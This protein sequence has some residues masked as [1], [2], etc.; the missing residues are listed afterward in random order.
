MPRTGVLTA[1]GNRSCPRAGRGPSAAPA[2][3]AP[4]PRPSRPRAATAAH[5]QPVPHSPRPPNQPF[6]TRPHLPLM[7]HIMHQTGS[8]GGDD[9]PETRPTSHF[10]P[11]FR[12]PTPAEPPPSRPS[13]AIPEGSHTR[14]S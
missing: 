10:D 1:H 13:D 12:P 4:S 8:H 9:T 5:H 7:G 14:P 6:A 11:R 3:P 2:N